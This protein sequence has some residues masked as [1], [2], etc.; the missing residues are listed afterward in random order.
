MSL[1][2]GQRVSL[3]SRRLSPRNKAWVHV[4]PPSITLIIS[5][6]QVVGSH[7]KTRLWST[8]CLSPQAQ[9]VS[10]L[11][12]G[13]ASLDKAWVLVL[14]LFTRLIVSPR[15]VA[16]RTPGQILGLRFASFHQVQS[17]SSPSRDF[18]PQDK[19]W[20]HALPPS[21]RLSVFPHRVAGSHR[22]TIFGSRFCL[23]P[24][25]PKCLF[26]D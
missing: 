19:V 22:R 4:F 1:Y 14:P 5:P 2:Q 3:T 25:G 17:V 21:N 12:H 20:V 7:P 9:R 13:L 18:A 16:A 8:F 11:S 23:F 15:R 6:R 24:P 10:S 26:A